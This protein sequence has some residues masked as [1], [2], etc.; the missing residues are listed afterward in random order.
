MRRPDDPAY[1]RRMSAPT[2]TFQIPLAVAEVY[3]A[4]FVPSIFAEWAPETLEAVGVGPGS[5]LLDVACGTGIVAR[6]AADLVGGEG[7]V[8]GVDLNRAMLTVAERVRPEIAWRQGDAADL[9]FDDDTFDAV[10]CQ[11][12]MMFFPDRRAAFAEM[13][14]VARPGGTVAVTVPA[15]L[16]DQPAY[17]VFVEIAARH[18]GADARALLGTYWNCGDL[19]ALRADAEAAGLEIVS[20]RTR[21][22]TARFGS[23]DAFVAT[24]VEGSPLAERLAA[25]T[26]AAIR[27]DVAAEMDRYATADGRFEAPLIGHVV[28]ARP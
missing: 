15:A 23:S 13:A 17:R 1:V 11:M 12:A 9:P 7:S 3:E 24:E 28:A 6:T 26:Y 16:E 19:P 18:A 21:E 8:T 22:G 5:D 20:T 4:T 10:T 14:R 27:A 2:E 25:E